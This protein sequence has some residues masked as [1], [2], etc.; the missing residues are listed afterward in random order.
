MSSK[1]KSDISYVS[2]SAKRNRRRRALETPVQRDLRLAACRERARLR[3]LRLQYLRL[4]SDA[5]IELPHSDKDKSSCN[6]NDH[7]YIG[8]MAKLC[9]HH[10]QTWKGELKEI[11]GMEDTQNYMNSQKKSLST[12]VPHFKRVKNE[13][14]QYLL[15]CREYSE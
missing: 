5:T 4:N 15:K 6:H 3:Y 9:S 11:L 12:T 10:A 14:I 8:A 13:Q 2:K 7:G 1:R